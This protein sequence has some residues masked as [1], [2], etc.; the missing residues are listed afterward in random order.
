MGAADLGSGNPDLDLPSMSLAQQCV[1]VSVRR[2]RLGRIDLSVDCRIVAGR[3]VTID[4][5]EG[6]RE[7]GR[8][9]TAEHH[10]QHLVG[11]IMDEDIVFG[12]A[13]LAD[14]D[15]F[16]FGQARLHAKA[17]LAVLTKDQ[18]LAVLNMDLHI[19]SHRL[20]CKVLED[21]VIIDDAI[22]EDLDEGCALVLMRA[23]Q[24][25]GHMFLQCIDGTCHEPSATAKRK[26]TRIQ[27]RVDRAH[28]RRRRPGAGPRRR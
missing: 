2:L 10:R 14:D 28:R 17:F 23:R 20:V 18:R 11:L 7:A 15:D 4:N 5:A 16:K 9:H 8:V 22:L 24:D 27:R 13:I 3:R 21:A 19:R 26:A 1:Q 25:A 12:N 6:D